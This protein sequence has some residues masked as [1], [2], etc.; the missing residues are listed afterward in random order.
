MRDITID[1]TKE[2]AALAAFVLLYGLVVFFFDLYALATHRVAPVLLHFWDY[3][4]AIFNVCVVVVV[5]RTTTLVRTYP[6]GVA[7]VCLMVLVV[8]LR[9]AAF[10]TGGS[11]ATREVFW[12]IMNLVSLGSS[13]LILSEG[14]RWF[15]NKATVS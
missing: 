2:K 4:I 1:S 12:A 3:L 6:F 15:R 13:L 9:I 7:G 14:V 5:C 11:A 8:L 10:W